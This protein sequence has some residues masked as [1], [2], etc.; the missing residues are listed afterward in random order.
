MA[1]FAL[2][3]LLPL[4]VMIWR[5]RSLARGLYSVVSWCF[6]AAGLVRGLLHRRLPPGDPIDS[7]VL[8]EPPPALEPRRKF[9][10]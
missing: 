8:R 3:A 1:V 6:N 10:A 2:L 9:Y 4:L 7:R 5:K